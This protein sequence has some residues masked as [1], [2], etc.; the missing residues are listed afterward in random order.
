G[1]SATPPPQNLQIGPGTASPVYYQFGGFVPV[2]ENSGDCSLIKANIYKNGQAVPGN[3]WG[4]AAAGLSQANVPVGPQGSTY[5]LTNVWNCNGTSIESG[6]SS[7]IS[8][9]AGP[10][11]T[12]IQVK[13]K[14]VIIRGTG[15]RRPVQV[16]V[17]GVAFADKPRATDI[18][19][20]QKGPFANGT[21]LEDVTNQQLLVTLQNADGGIASILVAK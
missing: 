1:G 21:T 19:I 5:V 9:P 2:T 20:V 8:V 10:K 4:S 17:N 7:A 18:E 13:R 14:T 6:A 16:F 3:L 15:F 12:S 11:I